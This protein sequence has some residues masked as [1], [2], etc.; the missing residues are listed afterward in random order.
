MTKEAK[1]EA[2]LWKAALTSMA[3]ISERE[4][5]WAAERGLFDVANIL[6]VYAISLRKLAKEGPSR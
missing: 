6:E 4:R 1:E 3:E 5:N 2:K